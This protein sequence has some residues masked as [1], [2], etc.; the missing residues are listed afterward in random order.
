[1]FK[2]TTSS[3]I[4][5]IMKFSII[6]LQGC[7]NFKIVIMLA[8]KHSHD[9]RTFEQILSEC[10]NIPILEHKSK[11]ISENSPNVL[12]IRTFQ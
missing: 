11:R 7:Q 3:F 10:M 4:F 5:V 6:I 8:T 9:S 1:M 12:S 2:E